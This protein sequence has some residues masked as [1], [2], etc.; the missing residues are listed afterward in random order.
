METKDLLKRIEG[1]TP[2]QQARIISAYVT[3]EMKRQT[4]DAMRKSIRDKCFPGLN[5][6]QQISLIYEFL[7]ENSG[8]VYNQWFL[9]KHPE[10]VK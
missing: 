3:N 9:R 4:V 7:G 5:K 2:E 8:Y 6:A 10:L 1:K